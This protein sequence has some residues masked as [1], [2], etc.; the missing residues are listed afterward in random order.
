MLCFG[1]VCVCMFLF[2]SFNRERPA[3]TEAGETS[4]ANV[5]IPN[6]AGT[7]QARSLCFFF[8][9]F[10]RFLRACDSSGLR[11]MDHKSAA[12]HSM[13]EEKKRRRKTNSGD[14]HKAGGLMS[15]CE[16]LISLR[17]EH[18]THYQQRR[19]RYTI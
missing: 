2:L 6:T 1:C 17:D 8:F 4:R 13:R 18:V 10:S 19:E 14:L 5:F 11:D 3:K 16:G 7:Q 9:L 12:K 15:N